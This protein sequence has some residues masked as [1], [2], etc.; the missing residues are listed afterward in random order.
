MSLFVAGLGR[1]SSKECRAVMLIGCMDIS[2]LMVCVHQVE[3]EKLRDKEEYR[4]KKGITGNETGQ[5][6]G[7]MN[8]QFFRNKRGILHHLLVYVQP[9]TEVN[10]TARIGTSR[11]G[12]H[13]LKVVLHKEVVELMYVVGM[14]RTTLASVV[15]ASQAIFSVG[16]RVTS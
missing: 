2:R 16:K 10:L 1:S 5:Q 4:K 11:L 9:E 13:S 8:G 6:K 12:Q 3:K 15:M 14:V 7:S